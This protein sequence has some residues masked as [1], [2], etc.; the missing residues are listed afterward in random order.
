[1]AA[2]QSASINSQ[3]ELVGAGP[4][5]RQVFAPHLPQSSVDK[6]PTF[7]NLRHVEWWRSRGLTNIPADGISFHFAEDRHTLFLSTTLAAD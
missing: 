5:N 7:G 2:P 6:A 4:E 1:M 3:L